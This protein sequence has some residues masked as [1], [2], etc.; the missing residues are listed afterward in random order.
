M[1]IGIHG[2]FRAVVKKH[3]GQIKSDTGFQKNLIT[4]NGL[5]FF[6]RTPSG[7]FAS[8]CAVGSGNSAPATTQTQLDSIVE[9]KPRVSSTQS[10]GFQDNPENLYIMSETTRF[11]F[12]GLNNANI[13]ELGLVSSSSTKAAYSL[14]TRAL[15]KDSG[16]NPTTISILSGETLDIYY[17]VYKVVDVT[18]KTYVVNLG[19]GAGN[20]TPYNVVVRPALVGVTNQWENYWEV[21]GAASANIVP[22]WVYT[23]DLV[24]FKSE[25]SVGGDRNSDAS[26]SISPYVTGS[27][28]IKLNVSIPLKNFDL[29]IRT[30]Y[31]KSGFFRFQ[32]RYG[33]V[34]NDTPIVKT[35]KDKL[36]LAFEFSWGRYEGAL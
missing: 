31:V 14:H 33:S 23:G 18:D 15:I 27:H 24:S 4:D 22:T 28:K 32:A 21:T 25:P 9:V 5:D 11:T 16:G 8:A 30:F 36:N 13:S 29:S 10:K 20:D 12:E 7:G 1:N 3:N 19:D 26:T 6:G 17:K 2:E 35:S 34:A